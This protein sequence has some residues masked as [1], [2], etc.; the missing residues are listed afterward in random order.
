MALIKCPECGNEVSEKAITCPHCGA[1]VGNGHSRKA[2][3][4][5]VIVCLAIAG[6]CVLMS[7]LLFAFA[8][9]QQGASTESTRITFGIGET[10]AFPNGILIKMTD[11]KESMGSEWNKPENG[12]IFA[13]VEFEIT[14][15]TDRELIVSSI[16][17][18]SAY[19]DDYLL[20]YSLD[21][22]IEEEEIIDGTIAPGKK[23]KGWIGWEV[24]NDHEKLEIHF[25]DITNNISC[26]FLIEK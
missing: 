8:N 12:N 21:A 6:I 23:L 2:N 5:F 15:N 17:D 1:R 22:M 18:F 16:M 13:L 20:N 25:S 11:C 7:I 26:I 10:A 4:I 9:K 24:P 14:N 3:K 19:A